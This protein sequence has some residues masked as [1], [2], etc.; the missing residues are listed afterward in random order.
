MQHLQTFLN[1]PVLCH[2]DKTMRANPRAFVRDDPVT[3][4]IED[5]DMKPAPAGTA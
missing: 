5:A 2:P 1:F 4:L 3:V